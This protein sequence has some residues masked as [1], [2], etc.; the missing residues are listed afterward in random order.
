[1]ITK[2]VIGANIRELRRKKGWN[3]KELGSRVKPK[4]VTKDTISRIER[5]VSNFTIEMLMGI[6]EALKVE[7]S[8]FCPADERKE[9]Y[10][11]SPEYQIFREGLEK[12]IQE[13]IEKYRGK[14]KESGETAS[15]QSNRAD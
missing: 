7:I 9:S 13:I 14:C 6:A 4:P 8:D 12:V 5:G 11:E 1:V 10:R 15:G 2:E 3:Q